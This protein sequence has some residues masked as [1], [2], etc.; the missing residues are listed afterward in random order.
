MSN[1][2]SDRFGFGEN[3]KKFLPSINQNAIDIAKSS[4]QEIF[5]VDDL[6][7]R[8]F[9]DIGCGSGLSSLAAIQLG[10]RVRSFDYDENSVF[11][12]LALREKYNISPDQWKIERGDVLDAEYLKSLGR[13]DCVYSWGVLHHTGDMWK[14]LGNVK[15][16]VAPGG[17]IS[18]AIYNDQGGQS[19]R[20]LLIKK[21]YNALPIM[22]KPVY[23]IAIVAPMEVKSILIHLVRGKLRAYC[24]YIANYSS[25]RGMNWW[26][27]KVD[28]VGGYPFEFARP[29]EIFNFYRNAGYQLV[30]MTTCAGGHG[31]NE[32]VFSLSN[33]RY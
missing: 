5:G 33:S 20:W 24:D 8:S 28:W 27:D 25:R 19:R 11:C 29:E 26:R 12:A 22:L 3:W 30:Y 31:C 7:G 14:A 1:T 15:L 2:D 16:N 32:F 4:L 17:K 9:L 10:A 6:Y 21:I 13:Y 23:L 18:I